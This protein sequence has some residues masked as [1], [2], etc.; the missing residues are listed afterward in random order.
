MCS[1]RRISRGH[2]IRDASDA[3]AGAVSAT[4]PPFDVDAL[5]EVFRYAR[6]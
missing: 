4:A 1:C 2:A 6:E 5:D 3:P